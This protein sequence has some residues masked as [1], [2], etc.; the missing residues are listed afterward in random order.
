MRDGLTQDIDGLES[1]S[2]PG[3]SVAGADAKSAILAPRL[4][5]RRTTVGQGDGVVRAS[6]R[7]T[8]AFAVTEA[9]ARAAVDIE[10]REQAQ[11]T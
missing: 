8:P 1:L 7:A 10:L 4:V 5:E 9:K 11:V 6:F 3:T 2:C